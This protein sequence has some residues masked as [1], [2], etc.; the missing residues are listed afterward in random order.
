M[1]EM[2]RDEHFVPDGKTYPD[3][4]ATFHYWQRLRGDRLAPAWSD[5]NLLD[6]PHAAI[7]RVCVVDVIP[8]PLDFIYRFWGTSITR[9]H[10]YDLTG[11]SV[12]DLTPASYARTIHRQYETV[13]SNR[14]PEGFLTE[15]PLDSGTFAY[16][17]VFRMPLSSD[18][19]H[20]DM[21]LSAEDY[22]ENREQM[23]QALEKSAAARTGERN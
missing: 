2:A 8:A 1:E 23:R 19:I 22:G 10:H 7:P 5:I 3:L 17:A 6:I 9:M 4:V 20:V 15:I 18:G 21:V 12:R 13:V 11:K 14:Q 16:Y